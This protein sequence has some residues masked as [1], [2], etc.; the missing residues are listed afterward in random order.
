MSKL[1][2]QKPAEVIFQ[3][4]GW[5]ILQ[6]SCNQRLAHPHTN[7]LCVRG[8]PKPGAKPKKGFQDFSYLVKIPELDK[9][10]PLD[11][12]V[13]LDS[14]ELVNAALYGLHQMLINKSVVV[15]CTAGR[16]RSLAVAILMIMMITL[17]TFDV[18]YDRVKRIK[19]SKNT[20]I[21]INKKIQRVLQGMG[22]ED[23]L[24]YRNLKIPESNET[25]NQLVSKIGK[26][27]F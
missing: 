11:D 7:G 25:V 9:Y 2:T 16:S 26:L 6:G 10:I 19:K 14:T 15:Y 12:H 24:G 13:Q 21:G 8:T 3:S 5:Y 1:L 22:P 18:V 20:R 23:V 17:E 4:N 27:N